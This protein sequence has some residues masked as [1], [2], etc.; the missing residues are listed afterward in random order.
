ML[1][2]FFLAL[3]TKVKVTINKGAPKL[4]LTDYS[5]AF[6]SLKYGYFSKKVLT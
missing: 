6:I 2:L 5:W 1:L 3:V 4:Y